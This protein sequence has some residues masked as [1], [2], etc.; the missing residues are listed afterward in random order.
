MAAMAEVL[1][2]SRNPVIVAGD[3]V[4]RRGAHGDLLALAVQLGASVWF[5]GM[6]Q[7]VV[8]PTTHPSC[9]GA[10]GF[11]AAAI[12]KALDGS[13][14]ILLVGGPF[15]EEVWFAPGSAFPA[16]A[17][18]LQVEDSP[19]RLSRNFA[20]RAGV[21]ASPGP[22]LRALSAAIARGAGAGFLAAAAS[23]NTALG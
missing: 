14:A 10:L 4:G 2:D 17:A 18:V 13:D 16:D 7:H 9:R 19:E 6:R 12:R 11:D 21:L 3:D 20:L 22:A 1:L 23:R 8:V 15:F 5:E